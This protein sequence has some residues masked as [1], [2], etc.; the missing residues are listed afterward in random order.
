MYSFYSL[1]L[2]FFCPVMIIINNT[3]HYG[4]HKCVMAKHEIH[5]TSGCSYLLNTGYGGLLFSF[6]WQMSSDASVF[7][8]LKP[9]PWLFKLKL[10]SINS[11]SHFFGICACL[12][13]VRPRRLAHCQYYIYTT[14]PRM[15]DSN[16]WDHLKYM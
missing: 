12:E 15:S 3:L 6:T 13:N 11:E 16:V 10:V 14:F 9:V 4:L 7:K 1:I 8:R 2:V 5:S